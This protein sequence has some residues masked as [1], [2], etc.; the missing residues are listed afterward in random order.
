MIFVF[1]SNEITVKTDG[2]MEQV[3]KKICKNQQIKVLELS[4]Q[5]R[6]VL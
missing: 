6:N 3:N 2:F 4:F 1:H 5:F